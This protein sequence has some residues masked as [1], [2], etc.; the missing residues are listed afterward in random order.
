MNI[1]I[2]PVALS[3]QQRRVPNDLVIQG[4]V[5]RFGVMPFGL[6]FAAVSIE[7][8]GKIVVGGQDRHGV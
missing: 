2:E 4:D 5:G 1:V 6:S 7:S 3:T 8:Q